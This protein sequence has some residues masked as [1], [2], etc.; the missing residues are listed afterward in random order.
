MIP[1]VNFID[2]PNRSICKRFIDENIERVTIAKG[3]TVKHQA[4]PGGY[5]DHINEVMTIACLLFRSLDDHRQL[6]FSLSDA[7]LTLFLHDLEKP[8]KHIKGGIDFSKAEAM[9]FRMNKIEEYG[10]VLTDEH[11]NAIKYVEGEGNDY[12]PVERMQGPLAAFIHCCDTLSA[13]VWFDK[14][15]KQ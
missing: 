6:G 8:W 12:H 4:W 15:E 11:L 14:P 1:L 9:T 5:V 10:F 3:S 13:R 7:L 2:E